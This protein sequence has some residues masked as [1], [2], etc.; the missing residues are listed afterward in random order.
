[1]QRVQALMRRWPP[2]TLARTVWRFGSN[3]RDRTLWAWLSVRPTTGVFPQISHCFAMLTSMRAGFG[4]RKTSQYSKQGLNPASNQRGPSGRLTGMDGVGSGTAA[5]N[6][7]ERPRVFARR[8]GER[9]THP[10]SFGATGGRF[11][12]R[13]GVLELALYLL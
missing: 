5:C 1:M 3:R 8:S 6:E 11:Q 7:S 13:T 9:M 4:S 10:S 12:R 2:L